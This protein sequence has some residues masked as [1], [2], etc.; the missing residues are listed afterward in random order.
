MLARFTTDEAIANYGVAFKY[1]SLL[2]AGLASV[3]IVLRPKLCR[4]DMLDPERQIDFS[5]KWFKYTA[6]SIIPILIFDLIGKPFY[7]FLNGP[8][9]ADSF[10]I[11]VI[12]STGVWLA[13]I[14]SPQVKILLATLNF[15][16]M[17]MLGVAAFGASFLINRLLVP[18]WGGAGAAVGT[19]AGN[20][21][22]NAGALMIVLLNRRKAA[23]K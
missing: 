2:L 20:T 22:I 4:T 12:L 7:V 19:V 23:G 10:T 5:S 8:V 16:A 6:W 3:T 21:V 9:Y 11:F 14:L 1:Y 17:F 18:V 13:L 15:R